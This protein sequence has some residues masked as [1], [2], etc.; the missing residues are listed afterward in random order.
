V[1]LSASHDGFL[2]AIGGKDRSGMNIDGLRGN[3][4]LK[5]AYIVWN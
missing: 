1:R 2:H 5:L 4:R 3:A